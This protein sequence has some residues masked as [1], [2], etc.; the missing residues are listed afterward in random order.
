MQI[1]KDILQLQK[2]KMQI[3]KD[4]IQLINDKL[5]NEFL[6]LYQLNFRATTF[7]WK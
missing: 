6:K 7:F 5:I 3:E 4:K 2:D 1:E